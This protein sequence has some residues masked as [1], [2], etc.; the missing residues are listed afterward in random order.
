[1]NCHGEYLF[2]AEADGL[3]AEIDRDNISNLENTHSIFREDGGFRTAY[4]DYGV[5]ADG[6]PQGIMYKPEDLDFT[7]SSL[8]DFLRDDFTKGGL[9]GGFWTDAMGAVAIMV[10]EQPGVRELWNEGNF[11]PVYDTLRELDENHISRWLTSGADTWEGYE[12]G[13]ISMSMEAFGT[14]Y[15]R[16]QENDTL[17]IM[18]P[19]VSMGYFDHYVRVRGTDEK[20]EAIEQ[21]LNHMLD[22]E[23]Q[24]AWHE[25]GNNMMSTE[26][27]EYKDALAGGYPSS[28]EEYSALFDGFIDYEKINPYY[29]QHGNQ[30][31]EIVRS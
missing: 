24:T 10:Q 2:Q 5:P 18:L 9:E 14:G 28:S 22:P 26:D 20:K 21:F 13:I 4:L 11:Q 17:E 12:Q 25:A 27:V 23:V 19:E 3:M 15:Q 31:D 30:F 8:R 6:A 16:A 29:E 1:M 7:P